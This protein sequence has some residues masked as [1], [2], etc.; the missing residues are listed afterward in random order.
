MKQIL[1]SQFSERTEGRMK[2]YTIPEYG[3]IVKIYPG[4]RGNGGAIESKLR[5]RLS[6]VRTDT[7]EAL[8]LGHA[9]EGIDISSKEYRT[10][11]QSAVE[12]CIS[13]L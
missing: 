3:I 8:V 11:L 2:T 1:S 5:N 9:C 4:P 10:G 6:K 13:H 12:A 7:L